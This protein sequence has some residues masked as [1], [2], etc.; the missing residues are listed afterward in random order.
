MYFVLKEYRSEKS[1]DYILLQTW[2]LDL[3]IET[4]GFPKRLLYCEK[5]LPTTPI[6]VAPDY[7]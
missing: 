7:S 3:W 4:A 2:S 5:V 6:F 1:R